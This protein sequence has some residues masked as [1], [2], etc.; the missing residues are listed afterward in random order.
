MKA[1]SISFAIGMIIASASSLATAAQETGIIH[2]K[3]L[4]TASTC[5]IKTGDDNQNVTL[6]TVD[7]SEFGD[8]VDDPAPNSAKDFSISLEKCTDSAGSV[9]ITFDS[10][11]PA[12]GT[13][14]ALS[15][16][17]VAG[18]PA[19]NVGIAIFRGADAINFVTDESDAKN[20]AFNLTGITAGGGAHTFDYTAKYVRT[21]TGTVTE[22]EA[23][24]D[25]TFKVTYY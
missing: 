25:A 17:S 16:S 3:G 14:K 12:A 8:N 21:G 4:V 18:T 11:S 1:K 13:Q 19:A 9:N 5:E 6:N 2:F 15:V 10:N 7:A 22:G 20:S 23:N 24:A